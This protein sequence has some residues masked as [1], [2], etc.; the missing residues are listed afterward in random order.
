VFNE[1]ESGLIDL[2]NL[3][4]DDGKKNKKGN[5]KSG[6][7]MD[8]LFPVGNSSNSKTGN[9]FVDFF[10]LKNITMKTYSWYLLKIE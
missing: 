5:Q 10:W 3:Q 1:V 7:D 9:N 4:L 2:G 6:N 8:D